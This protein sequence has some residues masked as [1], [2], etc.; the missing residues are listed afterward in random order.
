[1]LAAGCERLVY[2]S[3][4]GVLGL[5]GT[6]H[7]VPADETSAA[8][9]GHLF[10]DY[11]RTKF[12]AEHE[13]LRAAAEGLDVSLVLPT[14]PLG[15]G[16]TAPT[17]TGKLVV[18]FLN[19]KLPGYVHTALNVCHVDDLAAG[20]V[21]ALEHGRHGRSYILG[22]ENMSMREI[23]QELADC[24]KLPMPRLAVPASV[25]VVAGLASTLVEGRL[26]GRE[27]HVPYEGARMAATRMIFNDDRARAEIGHKSRPA[28]LAIEDSARWF[29]EHGYVT[30]RRLAA[31]RWQR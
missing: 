23:L 29:A 25:G 6:R 4:V 30:P 15:P 7:G 1:V 28:R 27:P 2:T 12:A 8:D 31:I 17:P 21:A 22:G 26:L 19:G 18:D 14:F 9:I 10:G 11:K 20:H 3:T 24:S 16:D 5:E 13:V